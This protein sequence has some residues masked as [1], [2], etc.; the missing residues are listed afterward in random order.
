MLFGGTVPLKCQQSVITLI[1][2]GIFSFI[3]V[4]TNV[5]VTLMNY[6]KPLYSSLLPFKHFVSNTTNAIVLYNSVKQTFEFPTEFLIN[7]GMHGEGQNGNYCLLQF[8]SRSFYLNIISDLPE[9]W[10]EVV[11][12]VRSQVRFPMVSSEF[13]IDTILSA[14]LWPWGWLSL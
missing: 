3:P 11:T 4:I 14:A 2:Q 5:Y 10:F 12:T 8:L 6:K 9:V 1:S 13:F 7:L